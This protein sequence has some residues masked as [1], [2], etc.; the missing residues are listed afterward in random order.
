MRLVDVVKGHHGRAAEETWLRTGFSQVGWC[1]S[2]D[3]GNMIDGVLAAR[4]DSEPVE[5]V[6]PP[7]LFP[8]I[9]P[10]SGFE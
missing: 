10:S 2:F 3:V 4:S 6:G 9:A 5:N 1:S 7:F 8:E